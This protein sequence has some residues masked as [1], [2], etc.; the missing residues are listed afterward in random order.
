MT[1]LSDPL[2]NMSQCMGVVREG[3]MSCHLGFKKRKE[4]TVWE[5]EGEKVRKNERTVI[6][7]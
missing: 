1:F 6:I 4:G 3:N 2:V 7:H 5:K